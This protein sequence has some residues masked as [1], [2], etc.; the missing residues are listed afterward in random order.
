MNA[1]MNE[2][3]CPLRL[4]AGRHHRLM[5]GVRRLLETTFGIVVKENSPC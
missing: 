3:D 2:Q 5:E 4:V 1:I